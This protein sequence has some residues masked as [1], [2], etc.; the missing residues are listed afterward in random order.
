MKT[1]KMILAI[2]SL[3]FVVNGAGAAQELSSVGPL[4]A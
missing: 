2:A 3:L 4:V 1:L